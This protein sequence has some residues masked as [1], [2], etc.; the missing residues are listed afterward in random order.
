[1][2]KVQIFV[3]FN[4]ITPQLTLQFKLFSLAVRYIKYI[5]LAHLFAVSVL[6][7]Y[8][9]LQYLLGFLGL[10]ISILFGSIFRIFRVYQIYP[11]LRYL[12]DF[13]VL[14]IFY[15]EFYNFTNI[16]GQNLERSNK[17]H[18]SFHFHCRCVC[19]HLS[20]SDTVAVCP[21][22]ANFERKYSTSPLSGQM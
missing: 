15:F 22:G 18:K 14:K 1:M 17:N 13:L 11:S 6:D 9:L 20:L 10:I 4:K 21:F 3:S 19:C 5:V 12:S 8:P 2:K 16:M 7:I